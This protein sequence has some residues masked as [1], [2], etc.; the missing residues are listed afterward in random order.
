MHKRRA[1]LEAL[2]AQLDVP[3]FLGAWI[4]RAPPMRNVY[5]CVT[6]FSDSETILVESVHQAP[7]PQVRTV[8]ISVNAWLRGST[9]HEKPEIDMDACALLIEQTLRKPTGANDLI[10]I[11]TDYRE[12]E[13]DP[14]IFVVALTYQ[15]VYRSIEFSPE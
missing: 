11:G 1:Y 15:L 8:N 3:G 10:L 13:N 7:R 2:K 12:D 14:E 4:Q 5:P 6:L 9:D